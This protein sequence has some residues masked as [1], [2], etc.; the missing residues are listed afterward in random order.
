VLHE[1]RPIH[2]I[3]NREQP[4]NSIIF[5]AWICCVYAQLKARP[6]NLQI[7][8][9]RSLDMD[10]NTNWVQKLH[11]WSICWR[12][13]HIWLYS[14]QCVVAVWYGAGLAITRSWVWISPVAAVHRQFSV[15][16]NRGQ[17]MNTKSKSWGVNRHTMWCTSPVSVVLQ[18]RLVSS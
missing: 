9:S 2:S 12:G 6:C 16:S 5:N 17:L 10:Y 14:M 18:L 11:A 8:H 13:C 4:F 1:T 15:P 7:A 3:L